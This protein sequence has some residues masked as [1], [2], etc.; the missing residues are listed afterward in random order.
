MSR[1]LEE[2]RRWLSQAQYDLQAARVN[3]QNSIYA[4]ACFLCQQAAEKA[5]KAFLY[6][7][8]QGP[9]IGHSGFRLAQEC[10]SF[11]PEF[12]TIVRAC[13]T[14]DSYYIPTRYPNGL[15][16]GIP[17]EV[18][19]EVDA[20]EALEAAHA[21]MSLVVAKIPTAASASDE[22]AAPE[23]NDSSSDS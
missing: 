20:A 22:T 8:G 23:E 14:L 17:H 12:D 11:D 10:A 4:W 2:A 5:L 19:D 15:P 16:G 18:Y 7:Q 9:V 1:N 13:K 21:V 6:A 3:E